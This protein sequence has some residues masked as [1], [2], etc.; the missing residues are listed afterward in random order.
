[1]Q[2]LLLLLLLLLGDNN[3]HFLLGDTARID[4][5]RT[6]VAAGHLGS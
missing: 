4:I 5:A 3:S 6:P 1:M 2:S